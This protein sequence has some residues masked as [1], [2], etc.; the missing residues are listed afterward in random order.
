MHAFKTI[1]MSEAWSFIPPNLLPKLINIT[2]SVHPTTLTHQYFVD[3][4]VTVADVWLGTGDG[5]SKSVSD[6]RTLMVFGE[7]RGSN[8]NLWS[9]SPYCQSGFNPLYDAANNYI[10]Y[11]GYYAFDL[12]DS[13]SPT[14]KWILGG[15]SAIGATRSP[16]LGD[17]WSKVMTGRVNIG[18]QEKWVGFIGAGYN[19]SDCSGGGSCDTRGKGFF[20][21][22]LS[23]GEILWSYSR[24]DNANM[25]YSLAGSAAVVDTDND[26]FIDTAYIGDNGGSLWRLKFCTKTMG[27]SC[28]TSNWTG[29]RLFASST[30]TIRP[31]Y[32]LPAVAIDG[33][34]NLWVYWGTGDK[35][36]PTAANAQEKLFGLKDNDRTTTYS[37]NDL[38]NI[39]ATGSTYDNTTSTNQGYYINLSGSGQKVLSDPTIFGGVVY[40]TT[41]N[42]ASGGNLC[43]QG[44]DADIFALSYTSGAGAFSGGA[45]SMSLGSGIASAPVVSMGPGS[46]SADLYVTVSG[47]GGST[48][49]TFRLN[50]TP[51]GVANRTNVL[52]WRDQR[53]Q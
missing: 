10:Y 51:P 40:F 11:C 6:W 13:L 42:A 22:D 43:D 30:G 18:T 2:H 19:G 7:G 1:D 45:R 36:D 44:G 15:A 9:S 31:I 8:P 48:G 4:P 26:G 37:I 24:A 41:Y 46:T 38:D 23:N 25:N 5:T 34:G 50:F 39:T 49:S 33:A 47:G 12:D 14:F 27:T 53:L 28:T 35:T 29:G 52:Y 17:P 3:G 21:I 16:Y 32:T 20:V